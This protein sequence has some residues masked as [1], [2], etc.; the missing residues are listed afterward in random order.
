MPKVSDWY[1]RPDVMSDRCRHWHQ[2]ERRSRSRN[3]SIKRAGLAGGQID[4][5]A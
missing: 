2:P 4:D 1:G 5:L 3:S